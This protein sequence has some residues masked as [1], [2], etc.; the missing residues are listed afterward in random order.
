M[1]T[2]K[3]T[4]SEWTDI[5]I[6]AFYLAQSIGLMEKDVQFQLEAKHVFWTNNPV[7]NSLYSILKQLFEIGFLE[8]R[9]E[10]DYQFRW[11]KEFIGSWEK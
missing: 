1:E 11:N 3:E 5:D 10:P 6:A 9:E 4:L 7:G 8:Y 2:L